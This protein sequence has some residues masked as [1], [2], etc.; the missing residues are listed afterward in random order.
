MITTIRY[1]RTINPASTRDEPCFLYLSYA[2]SLGALVC[3]ILVVIQMFQHGRPAQDLAHSWPARLRLGYLFA[4]IYGWTKA[5]EWRIK[6]LMLVWTVL[7]VLNIGISVLTLPSAFKAARDEAIGNR[8]PPGPS[9]PEWPRGR[10][11]DR[12]HPT[13]EAVATRCNDDGRIAFSIKRQE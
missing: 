9:P 3:Y 7:I 10:W 8:T 5:G 12:A 4:F 1:A 11:T 13:T 2:M 6:N